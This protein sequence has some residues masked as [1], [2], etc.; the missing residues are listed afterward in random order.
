MELRLNSR[1]ALLDMSPPFMVTMVNI[2]ILNPISMTRAMAMAM[3]K[4]SGRVLRYNSWLRQIRQRHS[5]ALY[6]WK[7]DTGSLTMKLP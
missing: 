6:L 1:L 7:K 3:A 4:R 2:L 5:A